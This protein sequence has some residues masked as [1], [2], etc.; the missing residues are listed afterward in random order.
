MKSDQAGEE[1][2]GERLAT[3][4]RDAL[5]LAA[6]AGTIGSPVT[7]AR[8]LE[9]IVETAAHVISAP[10]AALFLL[11][12]ESHEL[13]FE[14]ALGT[15]AEEAKKYRIPLGHGIAGL[16]AVSGQPMAISDAQATLAWPPTSRRASAISRERPVHALFYGDRII[17]VIELL[18]KEGASSFDATDIEA[19]GLFANMAAVALQ[20]SRTH[21][22]LA[23]LVDDVFG[24]FE[25]ERKRTLAALSEDT[26]FGIAR[27][28]PARA[29]DRRSRRQRARGLPD[30]LLAVSPTTCGPA[31][32]RRRSRGPAMSER[33]TS[34]VGCL[35]RRRAAQV[36]PIPHRSTRSRPTGRGAGAPGRG[37]GGRH[38]QRHRRRP[39]R[40][41]RH[42][43]G[44]VAIIE[45]PAGVDFDDEPHAD[46]FGHGTACAGIIRSLAP[47]CELYSVQVLGP[48]LSGRGVSSRRGLRWAIE[49]G[50]HVCNLSL[51]RPS[52]TSS[53]SSTS[54]PT[55]PTSATSSSSP[56]R[57]TCRSPS[58]PVRSTPRC[59]RSP[60]T[61]DQDPDVFYY[62]PEPPV[63][64]GAPGIDVRVA[65]QDG[66]WITATGNSFAAPHISGIVTRIL[67]KHP[68]LTPFQ[69]KTVLRAL[70]ANVPGRMSVTGFGAS[71]G[72]ASPARVPRRS[73][74]RAT[75][76]ASAVGR[77]LAG[78][79][80][81]Q[82]APVREQEMFGR[83]SARRVSQAG[84]VVACGGVYR[85]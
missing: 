55:W 23:A 36:D 62:N 39:S 26:A 79:E 70:A 73:G 45:G 60:L 50:M 5:T 6:T 7:H 68:E 9:M 71:T 76:A 20:Q 19:L 69:V 64:F 2:S 44:Y 18:D 56:P 38:R 83:R 82:T 25:G 67:G 54:W 8:L 51:G 11:D 77:L 3:H 16:V 37:Q 52:A 47:D 10:P 40:R 28:G 1:E 72:A 48:R 59:S 32:R 41:R 58:F 4:L 21:R 49:H 12:E 34:L 30:V 63:E 17:G 35:C 24:S 74:P 14:V 81:T 61:T 15:K 84:R 53:G 33:P 78:R 66:G 22:N 85:R 42:V 80:L 27:V 31:P 43:S 13:V 65:W 29:R 57:T 46:A 75:G